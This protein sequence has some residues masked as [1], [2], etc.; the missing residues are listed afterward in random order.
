MIDTDTNVH[1]WIGFGRTSSSNTTSLTFGHGNNTRM[2]MKEDGSVGI[3]T[4]TPQALLHVRR[5]GSA[6]SQPMLIES[7]YTGGAS[8]PLTVRSGFAASA[9]GPFTTVESSGA[10]G[11]CVG[12]AV[13]TQYAGVIGAPGNIT[14]NALGIDVGGGPYG[15]LGYRLG[16]FANPFLTGVGMFGVQGTGSYAGYF[17]GDVWVTNTM[18]ALTVI[19]RSDLRLKTNIEPMTNTLAKFAELR[20]VRFNWKDTAAHGDETHI[21][22]VAQEVET[23]FP[24]LVSTAADGLKGLSYSGISAA[25]VSALNEQ[26]AQIKVQQQE[27]DALKK[28][29]NR[30]E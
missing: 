23:V 7:K 14:N 30:M 18:S 1:G 28:R 12:A 11:W 9:T 20:S 27:I 21:G 29:L 6:Q 5:F 2:V 17:T 8:L 19:N 22:L 3:G 16:G 13:G 25:L 15:I 4:D 10:L 24:E 26:Q